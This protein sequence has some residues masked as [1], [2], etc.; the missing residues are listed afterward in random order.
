MAELRSKKLLS[1][2]LL[3]SLLI[4]AVML[5]DRARGEPPPTRDLELSIAGPAHQTAAAQALDAPAHAATPYDARLSEL[6]RMAES[7][8]NESFLVAIRDAGFVCYQF[9]SAQPSDLSDTGIWL[10][11]CNDAQSYLVGVDAAGML[12]VEPAPT[13]DGPSQDPRT[14]PGGR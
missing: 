4:A 6:G 7:Y 9:I 11:T 14:T 8:R 13:M 3:G 12:A 2:A 10:I 5:R 1:A